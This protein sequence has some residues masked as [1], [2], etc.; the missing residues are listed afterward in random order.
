MRYHLERTLDYFE[1]GSD[2]LAGQIPIDGVPFSFLQ[3]LF[4]VPDDDPMYEVFPVS[5]AQ[6]EALKPFVTDGTIDL[7][8]Y[9]YYLDCSGTPINDDAPSESCA[10][11]PKAN[12]SIGG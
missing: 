12:A 6:A 10:T 1:K 2:E 7:D 8:R 4:G 3:E 11:G 5:P 9:D